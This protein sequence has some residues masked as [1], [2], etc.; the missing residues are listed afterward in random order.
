MSGALLPVW[1]VGGM[2]ASAAVSERVLLV[3]QVRE[4]LLVENP[5]YKLLNLYAKS[6][7]DH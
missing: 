4:D 1:V 3:K 2:W 6:P 5:V 7:V